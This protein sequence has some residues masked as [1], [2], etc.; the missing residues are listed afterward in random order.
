MVW[1]VQT[2]GK[3]ISGLRP[4]HV[5]AVSE[6][7][8]KAVPVSLDL[9]SSLSIQPLE[10]SRSRVRRTRGALWEFNR[11]LS[12]KPCQTGSLGK[13]LLL[14]LIDVGLPAICVILPPAPSLLQ[15]DSSDACVS[16][17]ALASA[18]RAASLCAG[19][20]QQLGGESPLAD[21]MEV[22]PSD[23]ARATGARRGLKEAWNKRASR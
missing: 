20:A 19:H 13:R 2:T 11:F 14:M 12:E 1:W 10:G 6:A 21:L 22:R 7:N 4:S 16:I 18:A 8:G 15:E 3:H 5:S 23:D 9:R 17:D